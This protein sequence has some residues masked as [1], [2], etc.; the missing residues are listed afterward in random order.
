MKSGQLVGRKVDD[1]KVSV[2]SEKVF[3]NVSDLVPGQVELPQVGCEVEIVPADFAND[4]VEVDVKCKQI[5]EELLSIALAITVVESEVFQ[6][7]VRVTGQI[8]VL[9]LDAELFALDGEKLSASPSRRGTRE[10]APAQSAVGHVQDPE[11][12]LRR[13]PSVRFCDRDPS[14]QTQVK[15]E[16]NAAFEPRPPRGRRTRGQGT[17]PNPDRPERRPVA[18]VRQP[19]PAL[20]AVGFRIGCIVVV[21]VSASRVER[22]PLRPL[23]KIIGKKLNV[24]LLTI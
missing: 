8:D 13:Q 6:G 16:E 15:A 20:A 12:G 1:S 21:E 3:A 18:D 24:T 14:E 22:R 9:Q 7:F 4:I 11:V 5:G 2:G 23:Q 10:Q 17:L 19:S